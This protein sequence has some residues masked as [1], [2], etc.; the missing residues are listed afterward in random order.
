[1][2][3]EYFR[4]VGLHATP[5]LL[6]TDVRYLVIDVFDFLDLKCTALEEADFFALELDFINV[7]EERGLVLLEQ[8]ELVGLV[9]LDLEVD[10]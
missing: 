2:C 10:N 4:V 6:R 5:P 8:R 9:G 3:D 7:V 1:V